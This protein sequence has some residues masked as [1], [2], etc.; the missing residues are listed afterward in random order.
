MTRYNN[1]L[2][3]PLLVITAV[4]VATIVTLPTLIRPYPFG[5]DSYYYLAHAGDPQQGFPFPMFFVALLPIPLITFATTLAAALLLGL[6]ARKAGVSEAHYPVLL[7]LAAPIILMKFAEIEDD[8]IGV[9]FCLAAV[10]FLFKFYEGWTIKESDSNTFWLIACL[11]AGLLCWRGAYMFVGLFVFYFLTKR[12]KWFWLALPAMAAVIR[13]DNIVGENNIGLIYIP[14]ALLGVILG[15]LNPNIRKGFVGVW[16][17]WFLFAG[18]LRAKWLWLAAFPL[19]ILLWDHVR[20]SKKAEGFILLAVGLGL[21]VGMM[22]VVQGPPTA[23]QMHDLEDVV[24]RCNGSEINNEWW[25]GHY[26]IQLGG[27]PRYTNLFPQPTAYMPGAAVY[28]L[29]NETLALPL[30][31]DYGWMKLYHAVLS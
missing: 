25:V 20:F 31:R 28:H 4:I 3:I 5:A 29:T 9:A 18:L 7:L 24:I 15:V 12:S 19:A 23:T 17:I 10:Y 1:E 2:N 11:A 27:H 16:A 30:V 14:I 6:I 22:S 26:L 8:L 13:P 21:F